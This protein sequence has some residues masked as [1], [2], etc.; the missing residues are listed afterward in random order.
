MPGFEMGSEISPTRIAEDKK[1]PK[2]RW[3]NA[4]SY[5]PL[6]TQVGQN[7]RYDKRGDTGKKFTPETP[8]D[9]GVI[10]EK[11]PEKKPWFPK[12]K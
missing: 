6:G 8:K 11:K 10:I 12:S 3:F 7:E 2:K 1:N 5:K 4:D 9:G